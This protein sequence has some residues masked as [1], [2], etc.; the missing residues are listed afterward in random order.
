MAGHAFNLGS[1]KALG[2]VL[3]DGAP[4]AFIRQSGASSDG[5]DGDLERALVAFLEQHG[6]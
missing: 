3:F 6:R 5:R 4:A 1:P 2:E